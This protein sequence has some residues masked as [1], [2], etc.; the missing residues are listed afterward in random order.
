M[1]FRARA[2]SPSLANT[3]RRRNEAKFAPQ[4]GDQNSKTEV[5]SVA[6]IGLSHKDIHEAREITGWSLAAISA[7]RANAASAAQ[8]RISGPVTLTLRAKPALE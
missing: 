2:N 5:C 6:D 7:P 8:S 3:M 4:G 1:R